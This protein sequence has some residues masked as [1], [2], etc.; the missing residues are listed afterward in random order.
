MSSSSRGRMR[1]VGGV[2][3]VPPAVV[4]VVV[5]KALGELASKCAC[6]FAPSPSCAAVDIPPGEV[7]SLAPPT[8]DVRLVE[9]E[10]EGRARP[11]S[12]SSTMSSSEDSVFGA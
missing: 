5:V 9:D 8:A 10:L 3:G 12:S 1:D 11:A 2:R 4:V 6:W 7:P